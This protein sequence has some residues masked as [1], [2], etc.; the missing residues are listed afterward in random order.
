VVTTKQVS[1]VAL[2]GIAG[3]LLRWAMSLAIVDHGFPWATLLDNYIGSG[4]LMA[5]VVYSNQHPSPKWWWRPGLGAG[6]CGG[7]TTYSA[8]AV[9]VDEYM[10]AHEYFTAGAYISASVIGTYIVV[11]TVHKLMTER[12]AR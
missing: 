2:G 8:F 11:V 12:V 7:F 1:V 6:F 10:R 4:F 3:S 5:L 9:K